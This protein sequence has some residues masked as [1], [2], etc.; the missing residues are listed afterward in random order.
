MKEP[1]KSIDQGLEVSKEIVEYLKKHRGLKAGK[2]VDSDEY[3]VKASIHPTIANAMFHRDKEVLE[4]ERFKT[5][6]SLAR[7][8]DDKQFAKAM[9][10]L[11]Y[12]IEV[13]K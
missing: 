6:M 9:V 10:E 3:Q 5:M 2:G 1:N 4:H 11:G 8:L 7:V 13:K 12:S